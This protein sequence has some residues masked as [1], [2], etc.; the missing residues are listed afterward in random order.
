MTIDEVDAVYE[1]WKD[2]AENGTRIK[3]RDPET[4]TQRL[5]RISEIT[6]IAC[7]RNDDGR[8]T[9]Y[10]EI[11]CT[12][13]RVDL[14]SFQVG[15]HTPLPLFHILISHII[16]FGCILS[17]TGGVSGSGG[18]SLPGPD[19]NTALNGS[20]TQVQPIVESLAE[21]G[22]AIVPKSELLKAYGNGRRNPNQYVDR[23]PLWFDVLFHF[24]ME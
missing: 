6:V 23:D 12:T 24:D 18:Y 9:S 10:C 21:S 3:Y 17:V 2:R 8:L 7:N 4:L 15:D 16:D 19:E 5:K 20:E 11:I 22:I 13:P 1:I 14:S